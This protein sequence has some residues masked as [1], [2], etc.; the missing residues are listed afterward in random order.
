M[1][2]ED[3]KAFAGFTRSEADYYGEDG[4]LYCGVCHEPK[5]KW[6]PKDFQ[7]SACDRHPIQCACER[8]RRRQEEAEQATREHRRTVDR[9]RRECFLYPVMQGWTFDS[10]SVKNRQV[11]LCRQ[12]VEEWEQAKRANEGLLLWGKVGTGKTCLAACIANA[13]L[14]QEVAVR[15]TNLSEIINYGFEGRQAYIQKLCSCPLLI[16]DDL[17]MERD[18]KFGLETV[19]EIIDGR[20]MNRKPLI[21]T[22]NLT[23]DE[24]KHP[25]NTDTERIYDRLLSITVP[26][27]FAGENLRKKQRE[28][29]YLFMQ[30]IKREGGD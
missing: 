29:Q 25:K 20:L 19:F 14:E 28:E 6:F 27:R 30:G 21:V 17:G 18:T 15:M 9:L 5:E 1:N 12:Y 16:L 24:M 10:L 23:L 8:E 2:N 13:L 7:F 3:L 22:T 26:I 11:D 4:L